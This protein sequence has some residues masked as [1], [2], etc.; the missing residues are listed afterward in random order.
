MSVIGQHQKAVLGRRAVGAGPVLGQLSERSARC[1]LP[2]RIALG[3]VVHVPA[4]LAL[5]ARIRTDGDA[6][7][8]WMAHRGYAGQDSLI[9]SMSSASRSRVSARSSAAATATSGTSTTSIVF[10]ISVFMLLK[11]CTRQTWRAVVEV[12]RQLPN[13]REIIA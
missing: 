13:P 7:V 2:H 12:M 8:R 6:I 4:D 10:K 5:E 9:Q 3:G 11:Y 1:D